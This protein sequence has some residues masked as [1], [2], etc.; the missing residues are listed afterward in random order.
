MIALIIYLIEI[1][2]VVI[3]VKCLIKRY[4]LYLKMKK[5][6]QKLD[7]D[8]LKLQE[9]LDEIVRENEALEIKIDES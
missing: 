9:E 8:I 2:I 7:G 4:L 1:P 5:N 3:F 6:I